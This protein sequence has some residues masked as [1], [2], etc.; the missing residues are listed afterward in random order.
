V[1]S[2]GVRIRTSSQTPPVGVLEEV[3]LVEHDIA[4]VGD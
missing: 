3:D 4:Q 2:G 1:T